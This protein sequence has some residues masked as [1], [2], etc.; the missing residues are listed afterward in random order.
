MDLVADNHSGR[1]LV[2]LDG[3]FT[4]IERLACCRT[5]AVCGNGIDNRTF[6]HSESTIG[7]NNILGSGDGINRAFLLGDFKHRLI[8]GSFF[9]DN[10]HADKALALFGDSNLTLLRCVRFVYFYNSERI[11]L[12]SVVLGNIKGDGCA[13]EYI[14][15]GSLHLNELIALIV[16][17]HFGRNQIA[18]AV[19]IEC[20]D[21]QIRGIRNGHCDQSIIG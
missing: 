11:V 6:L 17:K 14:A 1:S 8:N 13:V 21:C 16:H 15:V 12:G 18:L 9:T 7:S 4:E 10:I 19:G 20:V 2:L 3:I 5:L